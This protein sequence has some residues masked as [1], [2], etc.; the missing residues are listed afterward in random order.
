M[1][2]DLQEMDKSSVQ[3]SSGIDAAAGATIGGGSWI[4]KKRRRRGDPG[5][6]VAPA[7]EPE[8]RKLPSDVSIGTESLSERRVSKFNPN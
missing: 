2:R 3:F 1:S 5:D 6:R 7:R 4:R 8:I